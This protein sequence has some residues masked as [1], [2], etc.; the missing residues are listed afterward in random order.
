ND[1]WNSLDGTSWTK[2]LADVAVPGPGQ[3]PR[4]LGHSSLVH[5]GRMWV[6][7]GSGSTGLNDVWSTTD[8]IQWNQAAA[9]APFPGR[10]TMGAL[11]LNN[12]IWVIGGNNT[13]GGGGDRNDVW[14]SP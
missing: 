1:V 6:I 12:Q 11:V 4:R 8:G 14:Y 7:A 10:Y 5:D 13:G 3:F 2:V 9:A